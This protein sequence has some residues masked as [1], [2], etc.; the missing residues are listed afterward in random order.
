MRCAEEVKEAAIS[1]LVSKVVVTYCISRTL[2]MDRFSPSHTNSFW[3]VIIIIQTLETFKPLVTL[4]T[5]P[6]V[7]QEQKKTCQF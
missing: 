7:H 4:I 2:S 5:L 1:T 3:L 6:D